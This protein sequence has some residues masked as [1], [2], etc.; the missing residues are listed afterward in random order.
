MQNFAKP[1]VLGNGQTWT[2]QYTNWDWARYGRFYFVI[3][4]H[5]GKEVVKQIDVYVHDHAYGDDACRL[6]KTEL[7][8]KVHAE[9]HSLA[10]RGES[11]S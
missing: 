8:K 10:V 9:L 4:I 5:E 1:T 6:S 7:G 2:A 11:L 3:S